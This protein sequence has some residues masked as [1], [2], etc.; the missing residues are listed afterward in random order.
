MKNYKALFQSN[1]SLIILCLVSNFL[2]RILTCTKQMYLLKRDSGRFKSKCS[3]RMLKQQMMLM[4]YSKHPVY[5]WLRKTNGS[6][7]AVI[8]KSITKLFWLDPLKN[9]CWA[10]AVWFF[11]PKIDR[12][13]SEGYDTPWCSTKHQVPLVSKHAKTDLRNLRISGCLKEESSTG[14]LATVTSGS[15]EETAR[16]NGH[17]AAR[18]PFRVSP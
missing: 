14:D 5:F 7:P 10:G 2:R 12:V 9:Y 3:L 15:W 18:T 1:I 16:Y 11:W 13:P 17:K 4:L 6:P 8:F